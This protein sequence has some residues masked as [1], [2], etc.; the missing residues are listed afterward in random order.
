MIDISK[1]SADWKTDGEWKIAPAG[2]AWIKEGSYIKI[3]EGA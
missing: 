2:L 1:F 3:G